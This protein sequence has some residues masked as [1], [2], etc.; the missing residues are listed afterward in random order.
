MFTRAI[1]SLVVRCTLGEL[2]KDVEIPF[3]LYLANN[4]T[5]LEKII[6]NLGTDRF[7]TFVE[8]DF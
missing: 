7:A 1:T 3:V 2:V 5:L 8:H 4:S 6:G